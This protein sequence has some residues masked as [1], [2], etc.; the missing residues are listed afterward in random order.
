MSKFVLQVNVYP[1][2][3][4]HR[5]PRLLPAHILP[6]P[7]EPGLFLFTVALPGALHPAPGPDLHDW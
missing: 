5:V 2:P 3:G 4:G 6:A 7:A 1:G